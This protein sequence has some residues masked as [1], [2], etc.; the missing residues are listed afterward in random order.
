[1]P[2]DAMGKSA[3]RIINCESMI[4]NP[5]SEVHLGRRC[6]G[7]TDR[8]EKVRRGRLDNWCMGESYQTNPK[9]TTIGDHRIR[10]EQAD[11]H[12]PR[13]CSKI[14]KV[15]PTGWPTLFECLFAISAAYIWLSIFNQ[16]GVGWTTQ[17]HQITFHICLWS[18]YAPTGTVT[19]WIHKH[20]YP[21]I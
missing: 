14:G 16:F 21:V 2:T 8:S 17:T 1:M 19:M 6:S 15:C 12:G 18:P 9:P 11:C 13:G 4:N 20:W 10:V 7:K 5:P 3:Q